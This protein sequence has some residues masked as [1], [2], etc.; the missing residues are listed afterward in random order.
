MKQ[1]SALIP[2]GMSAIA[3]VM[4]LAHAAIYGV[5]HEADEGAVAHIFQLLI[6]GQAPVIL[7]YVVRWL[8]R[9]PRRTLLM[10]GAQVGAALAAL[11]PVYLL[12]L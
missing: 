11:A 5:T 10:L 7:F 9:N 6:A 2:M 8:P 1:P 4:V 12:G 3:L